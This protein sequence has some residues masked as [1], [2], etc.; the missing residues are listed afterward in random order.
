LKDG[1][2]QETIIPRHQFAHVAIPGGTE[3]TH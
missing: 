2:S 3:R 1:S